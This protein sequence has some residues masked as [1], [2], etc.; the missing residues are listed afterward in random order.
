MP[1][2]EGETIDPPFPSFLCVFFTLSRQ[3][4]NL[5]LVLPHWQSGLDGECS[6]PHPILALPK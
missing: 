6:F 1:I 5:S 2:C 3:C 4:P